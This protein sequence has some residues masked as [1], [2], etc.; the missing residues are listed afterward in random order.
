MERVFN[1]YKL[2]EILIS[3]LITA[4]VA[5]LIIAGLAGIFV[6]FLP[7]VPFI[8]LGAFIYGLY[9]R[10]EHIGFWT[11][12]IL[13][14]L[15]L[16]ITII[17]Y[18]STTIGARKFGASRYGIIGGITGMIIGLLLGSVFGLVIGF[19]AGAVLG[20]ILSGRDLRKSLKS[21]GGAV[22]GFLGGTLVKLFVALVMIAVFL[23]AVF[24]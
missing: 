23:V 4:L 2:M 14:I 11:Y 13:I 8:L 7:D 22:I 1:S 24:V 9:D 18:L 17:D 20:E 5:A 3:I 19:I 15:A 12:F 16:F 6:P 10:F 21:G